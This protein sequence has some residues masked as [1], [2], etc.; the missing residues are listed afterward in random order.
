MKKLRCV[1]TRAIGRTATG[2][3]NEKLEIKNEIGSPISH[4]IF[5]TNSLILYEFQ[6]LANKNDFCQ[7]QTPKLTLGVSEDG[8]SVFEMSYFDKKAFLAQSSQ[9]YKQMLVNAGFDKVFEIGPSFRAE[10]IDTTRNFDSNRHLCEFTS[11]DF[12]MDLSRYNHP[13]QSLISF[14]WNMI[15]TVLTNLKKKYRNISSNSKKLLVNFKKTTI[16]KKP[17]CI[18]FSKAVSLLR[19]DG[20]IQ[21][22]LEALSNENEY[23]LGELVKK[24][25][26]TDLFIITKYPASIKPFYIMPCPGDV[27]CSNSFDVIYKG[28]EICTG[29]QRQNN[30]QELINALTTREINTSGFEDYLNSFKDVS[31]AHGGFGIGVNRIVSLFL[32]LNDVKH[33]VLFADNLNRITS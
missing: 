29:G 20:K 33:A 27:S 7:V 2:G 31:R 16:S 15:K 23:R 8:D 3:D 19:K 9:I 4:L 25:Y 21:N 28:Q 14:T 1:S 12:E 11:V 26:D 13:F 22:Q 10:S 30:Y 18:T 17:T 32:G 5:K 24:K 6:Q